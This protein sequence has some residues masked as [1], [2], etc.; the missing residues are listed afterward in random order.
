MAGKPTL[1]I[2]AVGKLRERFWQD[3][4]AEYRKRLSAYTSRLTV[5]EVTDEPTPDSASDAQELAI[6]E[7]EGERILAQM[8]AR[9]HVIALDRQG[10]TMDSPAFAVYIER[11]MSEEGVS[12]FTY[13]IGGSLGLSE[14]V[15]ARAN[16]TLSFGAFTFPHQL[17]R[18]ILLEQLY[19]AAKITRNES[20]HK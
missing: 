5:I 18:V 6:R 2:I 20:Y 17:M 4:E 9:E 11:Q 12:A 16:M 3:A 1:R 15:L 19:R 14:A 7:R 13:V 8:G 10:R